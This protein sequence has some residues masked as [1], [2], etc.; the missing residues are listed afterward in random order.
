[1]KPSFSMPSFESGLSPSL[2]GK[3]FTVESSWRHMHISSK[4]MNSEA[5]RSLIPKIDVT[6]YLASTHDDY[7]AEALLHK[8]QFQYKPGPGKAP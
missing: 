5:Y 4:T 2:A 8:K 7:V 3:H 1:M 6:A